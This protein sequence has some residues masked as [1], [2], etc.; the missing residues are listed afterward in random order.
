M[1]N[2]MIHEEVA[3]FLSDKININTYNYYLGILAPDS[4]N[5]FGFAP[6]KDRWISHVR[7]SDYNEWRESLK[8]FYLENKDLYDKD[9]LLGYC[10]HILTDIIYDDY[11]YLNVRE[12]IINDGISFDDSHNVMRND[13]DK[14]YFDKIEIIKDILDSSN[15]SFDIN[16]IGFEILLKWKIKCINNFVKS[17]TSKYITDSVIELLNKKVLEEVSYFL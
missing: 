3:Y 6:K 11:I 13:M 12:E 4:V 15:N 14:Y 17:N 10:V 9:F 5:L 16:N 1:P 8:K 2:I 7:C